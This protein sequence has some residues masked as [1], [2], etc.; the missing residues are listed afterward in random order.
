MQKP[1]IIGVISQKGGVGKTTI[2]INLAIALRL[3]NYRV[4]LV[5]SDTSNPSIGLSLG[6]EDVDIGFKE[7]ISRK[8]KIEKVVSTHSPTGLHVIL[9]K[10]Q[11]KPFFPSKAQDERL[12]TQLRA[13]KYDYIVIDTS[14]GYYTEDTFKFW[15]EGLV[16][17][18]PDMPAVTGVL[19][20][21]ET[22]KRTKTK[23]T[24]VLN[25][26]RGKRYELRAE[27]IQDAWGDRLIGELPED[28]AVVES[29]AE[30][31]PVFLESRG[32]KFSRSMRVIADRYAKMNRS[33]RRVFNR[34]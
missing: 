9:G 32:S 18:T 25:R 20:L 11:A 30:R 4:L 15:N 21:R 26:V 8:M 23:C 24:L 19:R 12:R 27:E 22:F 5:D 34:R 16:V 6:M 28:E 3:M 10:L 13:T 17:A 29:A 14:P 1:F 31:M 33:L 7:L 2:A